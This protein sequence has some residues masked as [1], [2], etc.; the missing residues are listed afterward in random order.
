LVTLDKN[1]SNQ[2]DF[3]Y[4]APLNEDNKEDMFWQLGQRKLVIQGVN[5][6]DEGQELPLGLKIS[7]TG[8]AS[9]K[10]E[11]LENMD[12]NITVHIKD[13]FTGK[14]YNITHQPFEIELESGEYLDRFALVFKMIKL[15][16]NDVTS[17]VLEVAPDIEDHNYQVF[18]NNTIAELQ[19][20]N[21]GTDEIRSITLFNILGQT[22]ITWNKELNRRIIS[23]PVKLATG[24][25]MVQINTINGS[26]NKRIIIE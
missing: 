23:L 26:N 17:G 18:M 16:A 22:M 7:K 24:V 14:T 2:F 6:F 3:G 9:I 21:N 13:K 5:N 1:T 10:I 19:I 15:V 12:E 20:K 11:E 25:Y 8:L 4:D